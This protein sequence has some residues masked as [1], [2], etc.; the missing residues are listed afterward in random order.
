MSAHRNGLGSGLNPDFPLCRP[1]FLTVACGQY[2]ESS[3]IWPTSG[4]GNRL[5][6][7]GMYSPVHFCEPDEPG[8]RADAVF[9]L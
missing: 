1:G 5:L 2:V 4:A 6:L 3:E 8:Q 7:P 9:Q